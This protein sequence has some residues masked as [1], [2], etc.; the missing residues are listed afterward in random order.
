[1]LAGAA[2]AALLWITPGFTGAGAVLAVAAAGVIVV[3]RVLVRGRAP[4]EDASRRP[5]LHKEAP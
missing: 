1:V 2:G 5:D 3:R 4:L